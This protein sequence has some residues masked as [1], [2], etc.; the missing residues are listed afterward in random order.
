MTESVNNNLITSNK[1]K[2]VEIEKLRN[3]NKLKN[4]IDAVNTSIMSKI[5]HI[6]SKID[7]LNKNYDTKKQE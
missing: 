4:V 5:G 6:D 1:W 7:N 3:H 2:S